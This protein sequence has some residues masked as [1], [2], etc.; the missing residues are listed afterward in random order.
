MSESLSK[1]FAALA[2]ET[3]RDLV[4]R[5]AIGDA[6]LGELAA[7]YD[8]SLQAVA[9]HLKVLEAAGLVTRRTEGRRRPAHLEAEALGELTGWIDRY[10]RLAEAR[11][12]RLDRLLAELGDEGSDTAPAFTDADT[13]DSDTDTTDS[14][15]AADVPTADPDPASR[16]A[17]S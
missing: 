9:K 17:R 2:D 4:A 3:R 13:T 8:M 12:G 15:S 14:G 7:S 10:Q 6:T 16:G 1:A 5:L 11:F